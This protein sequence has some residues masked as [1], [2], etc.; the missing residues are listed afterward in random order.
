VR[1]GITLS[2][3]AGPYDT[4]YGNGNDTP[5]TKASKNGRRPGKVSTRQ[6]GKDA[7]EQSGPLLSIGIAKFYTDTSVTLQE[8]EKRSESLLFDMKIAKHTPMLTVSSTTVSSL[9][10]QC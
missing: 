9:F 1:S 8:P 7:G 2:R 3:A 5:R 10:A 6:A 4:S